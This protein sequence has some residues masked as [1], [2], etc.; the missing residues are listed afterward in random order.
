MIDEKE[1]KNIFRKYYSKRRCC[2]C[3]SYMD[4]IIII[5]D[6]NK[7]LYINCRS[8]NKEN[9]FNLDPIVEKNFWDLF[10][11]FKLEE[12]LKLKEENDRER[13]NRN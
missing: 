9:I 4:H 1:E 5:D 11:K 8:C 6:F 12:E 7:I 2:N 13:E 3:R 10:Q